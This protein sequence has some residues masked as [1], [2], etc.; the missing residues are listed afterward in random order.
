MANVNV[1]LGE[2]G[3]GKSTLLG[4]L[5]LGVLAPVLV[6]QS[7]FVPIDLIN[8]R[9]RH[10]RA[11]LSATLGLHQQ[12]FRQG[13]G[14]GQAR[15]PFQVE[16]IIDR[17]HAHER[18]VLP[19]RKSR[20][21][22]KE[23]SL[24][25]FDDR[26]AAFFVVGYAATRRVEPRKSSD[27]PFR[28]DQRVLRYQRVASLIEDEV[29]L[30]PL[31]TWL[32]KLKFENP[33]RFKQV[34]ALM[35]SLLPAEV[36][37]ASQLDENRWPNQYLYL[38]RAIEI[39][40]GALSDG[41][42]GYVGWITDL[43]YHVCM[44]CPAG[45]KLV[46]NR[47]LVLVDEIDRHLH[48]EWQRSVVSTVSAA[49]PNLQFVFT[50]HSPIVAGSVASANLCV[51]EVDKNGEATIA[52]AAES[53]YGLASDQVLTSSLFKLRTTRAPQAVDRIEELR[54]LARQGD[55]KASWEMMRIMA[56]G[57]DPHTPSDHTRKPSRK[58]A[59]RGR[60]RLALTRT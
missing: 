53:V 14:L 43:L 15:G 58:S 41:Y 10:S 36:E 2:N 33:T 8:K 24:Q 47:G 49:L 50:T 16:L 19:R 5:A 4:A 27:R 12:D 34:V 32:P 46:D 31:E 18:C 45:A 37:F 44:G 20:S 23:L 39:P 59:T 52:P 7:G 11:A 9:A 17:R 30:T 55:A 56:I 29:T 21:L 54:K 6:E 26:S 42:R 57:L 1:L 38:V 28:S 40:F 35:N 48:P 3:S 25:Y 51:L 60:S 13:P 22:P